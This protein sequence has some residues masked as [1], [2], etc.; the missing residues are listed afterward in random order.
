MTKSLAERTKEA[1]QERK[2]LVVPLLGFPGVQLS[3]TSI[4][5]AQQNYMDAGCSDF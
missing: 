4:E 3:G 5:L 2:R 1:H